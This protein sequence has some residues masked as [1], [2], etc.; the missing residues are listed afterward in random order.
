MSA[1]VL[2]AETARSET[3]VL[4][5]DEWLARQQEYAARVEPLL[6]P[7][8]SRRAAGQTHPIEDFLF[9]YYVYRPGQLRRWHPGAGVRLRDAA[10]APHRE[11]P[12][13]RS[14]RDEVSVDAASFVERRSGIMQFVRRLMRSTLDRAGSF[15]CFGM[16]EWAMV[17]RQSED[18]VRHNSWPLRLDPGQIAAAVDERDLSCTHFDAFRFFTDAARPLNRRILE[19]DDQL[20]FEQPGCL[21]AGMDLYKWAYKLVP[22]ISSDL[23]LDCFELAQRIRYVDMQ[24]SPYDFTSLGVTPIEVDTAAGRT[25]YAKMQRE[26]TEAAAPLRARLLESVDVIG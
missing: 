8:E 5:R 18:E 12:L 24:A 10:D 17:Y 23:V 26:F 4:S 2:H 14:E 19:R 13:Y 9:I 3:V 7:Y 20:T 16:H 6:A 15:G 21:H 11:W 25:A 1:P 22:L